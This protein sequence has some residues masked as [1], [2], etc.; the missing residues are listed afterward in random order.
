M[1]R[2]RRP[3][4]RVV[5]AL[6]IGGLVA[7]VVPAVAGAGPRGGPPEK[8]RVIVEL[9]RSSSAN[10][11]MRGLGP[12]ATEV[13][14]GKNVP[15]VLVEVPATALAGLG[16]N[17]HVTSITPDIPEPPALD[18][19]LPVINGDDVQA[20]GFTGAGA[21]VAVLDTG[22]DADH[23]FYEDGGGRQPHRRPVLLLDAC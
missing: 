3:S 10:A 11:V 13:R 8:V 5:V 7:G 17:P 15:Y 19:T 9:D 14:R 23:P 22:I 2:S 21:T 20:L 4:I 6:A 1:P 12:Q 16:H 18:T